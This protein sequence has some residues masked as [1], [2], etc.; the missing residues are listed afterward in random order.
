MQVVGTAKKVHTLDKEVIW[1][2][3][4]KI[5]FRHFHPTLRDG[6]CA[7]YGTIWCAHAYQ[8]SSVDHI[9]TH[10]STKKQTHINDFF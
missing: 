4:K 5:D 3:I 1:K 10:I 6:F 7:L 8:V 9:F 2:Y